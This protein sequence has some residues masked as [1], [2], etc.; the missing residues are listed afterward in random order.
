[1]LA[2]GLLS[3][4]HGVVDHPP[5]GRPGRLRPGPDVPRAPA[6]PACSAR[7]SSSAG[8]ITPAAALHRPAAVGRSRSSG[9]SSSPTRA[10]WSTSATCSC[11]LAWFWINRTRPGPA[12]ARGRRAARRPPTPWASTSTATRYA[13]RVRRR[14]AGRA[15]RR[16]DHARDLTRAGSATRRVNGRGWIAVGLVIFAQWSPLRAADRRL[17]V[18]GDLPVHPRHPGRRRRSSG[19]TNPFQRQPLGDVL[20]RDAA[21]RCS[22]SSS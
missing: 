21:V 12:P 2:G 16:D 17:P 1:M 4:L 18:R 6:S 5:P 19:S 14:A 9:R 11:P 20:P 7:A 22:S 15:G 3:L 10:S 8:A 13:L